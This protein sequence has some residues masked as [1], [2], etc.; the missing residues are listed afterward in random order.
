MGKKERTKVDSTELLLLLEEG[1]VKGICG[2][3]VQ[4]LEAVEDLDCA[5]PLHPYH[6]AEYPRDR[7]RRRYGSLSVVN[8]VVGV[9]A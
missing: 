6:A 4:E 1:A 5:S 9:G 7:R 3:I 2:W 8:V